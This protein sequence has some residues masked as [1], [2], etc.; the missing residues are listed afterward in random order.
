MKICGRVDVQLQHSS[1]RHYMEPSGQ[2]QAPAALPPDKLPP[3]PIGY[4]D[5]WAPELVWT[6]WRKDK[7]SHARNQTRAVQPV[8]RHYID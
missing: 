4:D 8:A 7:I 2:L 3:L 6:L 5:G 1:F